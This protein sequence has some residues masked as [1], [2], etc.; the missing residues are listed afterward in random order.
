MVGGTVGIARGGKMGSE[1]VM[2]S[3]A[4]EKSDIGVGA[5]G[6]EDGGVSYKYGGE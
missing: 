2:M 6:G 3:G 1:V 4:A 5:D